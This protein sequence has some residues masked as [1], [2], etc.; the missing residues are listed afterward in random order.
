MTVNLNG[1]LVGVGSGETAI[2]VAWIVFDGR[3]WHA[4]VNR[5]KNKVSSVN[6]AMRFGNI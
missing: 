5:T 3:T 6:F 4:E 1:V 2:V